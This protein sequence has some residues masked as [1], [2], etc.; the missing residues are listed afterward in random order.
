MSKR[1]ISR[2]II[3]A[4]ALMTLAGACGAGAK[5]KADAALKDAGIEVPDA[6]KLPANLPEG[7]P[8]PTL[9]LETG[10]EAAGTFTLRYTSTDAKADMAAYRTALVAAGYTISN[11]ADGLSGASKNVVLM[12]TKGASTILA[13]A[14]AP[15]APGG[16]NYMGVVVTPTP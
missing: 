16:G 12:A 6:G 9:K 13:S 11:D 1:I 14:F 4:A 8:T 2:T 15:D 5:D 10:I 3:S 7:T